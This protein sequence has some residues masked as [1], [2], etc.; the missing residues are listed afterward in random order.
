VGALSAA[1]GRDVIGELPMQFHNQFVLDALA[2]SRHEFL[3][4]EAARGRLSDGVSAVPK[5]PPPV[6]W[7]R[8]AMIS[9]A[10][11][12]TLWVGAVPLDRGPRLL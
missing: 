10:A 8:A 2:H 7:F 9:W 11:C 1:Y 5:P 3:L 6:R 12:T 4:D